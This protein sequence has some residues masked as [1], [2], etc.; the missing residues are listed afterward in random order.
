MRLELVSRDPEGRR[1]F[2]IVSVLIADAREWS[3]A[4]VWIHL[5]AVLTPHRELVLV[6]SGDWY[7]GF[8]IPG[9]NLVWIKGVELILKK[10][11]C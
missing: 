7:S 9:P 3:V 10:S 6:E 5:Y 4:P 11:A 1:K 2:Q 8:G